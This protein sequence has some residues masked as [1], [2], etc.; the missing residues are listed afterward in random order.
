[1]VYAL[2]L[3][4]AIAAALPLV[5]VW[6]VALPAVLQMVAQ[7]RAAKPACIR[8]H[9]A[10]A[11]RLPSRWSRHCRPLFLPEVDKTSWPSTRW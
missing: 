5:P 9:P 4:G 11:R 3:A 1:M 10:G 7:V 2:T 6:L 8:T